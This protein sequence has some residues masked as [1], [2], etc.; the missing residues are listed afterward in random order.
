MNHAIHNP[1][2]MPRRETRS[3]LSYTAQMLVDALGL[4][5]PRA[6]E[7]GYWKTPDGSVAVSAGLLKYGFK[8]V[9]QPLRVLVSFEGR[10]V[11]SRVR[12]RVKEAVGD[13]RTM[14][15][16]ERRQNWFQVLRIGKEVRTERVAEIVAE[17]E[18]VGIELPTESIV[19]HRVSNTFFISLTLE[20]L[21]RICQLRALGFNEIRRL[22]LEQPAEKR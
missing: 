9:E 5:P 21:R 7:P 2:P 16:E 1:S 4:L 15:P 12:Q 22:H 11:Q 14:T 17:L 20:T 3:A 18:Q 19:V 10:D 6:S 8:D 13:P